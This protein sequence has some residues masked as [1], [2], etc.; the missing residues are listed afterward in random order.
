MPVRLYVSQWRKRTAVRIDRA[1]PVIRFGDV[2]NLSRCLDNLKWLRIDVILKWTLR[3]AQSIRI[4]QA[5]LCRALLLELRRPWLKRQSIF[6]SNAR[7]AAPD[8]WRPAGW[9]A[10]RLGIV[11]SNPDAGQVRLA[12]GCSRRGCLEVRLAV[13]AFRNSWYR[14]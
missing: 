6:E 12:V 4:V 9:W 11:K 13:R 14:V 3:Q 1:E 5:I 2:E 8:Q 10:V 7:V